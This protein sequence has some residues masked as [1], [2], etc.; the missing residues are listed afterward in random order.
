MILGAGG[1]QLITVLSLISLPP[2]LNAIMM[3]GTRILF[4]M[5]RDG[6]FWARTAT[7]NE[8]GTPGVAMLATTAVAT[9]LIATGTFRKL[10]AM[11]SFFLAGNYC[12]ACLALVVLRR[13]EPE[14][15]RPFRAWAYPWS[16]AIV[17]VGAFV[18]LLG[19]LVGDSPNGA[20]AV[21]LVAVGLVGRAMFHSAAARGANVPEA[22][23]G[24]AEAGPY[25]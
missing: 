17:L 25:R 16:A 20:A 9:A 10:V 8:A 1:G 4:A 2:L 6:L 23:K 12:V 5:G 7:I 21:G 11:T 19:V 13:R 3:I 14:A 15:P 18:F 22:S 24:P